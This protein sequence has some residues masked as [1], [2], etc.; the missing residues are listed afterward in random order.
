MVDG[1][2]EPYR[3]FRSRDPGDRYGI[4]ITEGVLRKASFRKTVASIQPDLVFE[5]LA[6]EYQALRALHYGLNFNQFQKE[7]NQELAAQGLQEYEK[8]ELFLRKRLLARNFLA[9]TE[10]NGRLK[11][12]LGLNRSNPPG[13][14]SAR[15]LSTPE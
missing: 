7:I 12:Y 13:L 4:L 3:L 10:L 2:P 8:T 11:N 9:L 14:D 1:E 5:G 6:D 15:T